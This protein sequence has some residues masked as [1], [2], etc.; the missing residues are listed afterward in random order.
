MRLQAILN[1]VTQIIL[2]SLPYM[3]QQGMDMD[4]VELTRLISKYSNMPELQDIIV[5][6][7]PDGQRLPLNANTAK[8]QEGPRKPPVTVRKNERVSRSAGKTGGQDPRQAINHMMTAG[9]A[10]GGGSDN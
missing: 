8:M 7:N 9:T 3:Q 1:Y 10:A 4:Y 5:S 2:P 6:Q